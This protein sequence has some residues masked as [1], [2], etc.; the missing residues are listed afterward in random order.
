[1]KILLFIIGLI[2]L[3]GMFICA[4]GL[5]YCAV[6]LLILTF[7]GIDSDSYPGYWRLKDGKFQRREKD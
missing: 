7:K 1:M 4:I 3:L 6:S 5:I 2:L